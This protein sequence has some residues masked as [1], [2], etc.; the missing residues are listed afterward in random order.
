M[1]VATATAPSITGWQDLSCQVKRSM[2]DTINSDVKLRGAHAGN[3]WV[4]DGATQ[5]GKNYDRDLELNTDHNNGY[6]GSFGAS[7]PIGGKITMGNLKH[8][9][10]SLK[11]KNAWKDDEDLREKVQSLIDKP[12]NSFRAPMSTKES[13]EYTSIRKSSPE[14]QAKYVARKGDQE[15]AIQMIN[16]TYE[17][18]KLTAESWLKGELSD[19]VETKLDITNIDYFFKNHNDTSTD[20]KARRQVHRFILGEESIVKMSYKDSVKLNEG[21]D[22]LN[23]EANKI[24][25]ESG[26]EGISK[27][28]KDRHEKLANL[29]KKWGTTNSGI[30]ES[31]WNSE[32]EKTKSDLKARA[33]TQQAKAEAAEREKLG[34]FTATE[35][36]LN[37]ANVDSFLDTQIHL[38]KDPKIR[39]SVLSVLAGG[40]PVKVDVG[41]DDSLKKFQ[42]ST[43]STETV[44]SE[45]DHETDQSKLGDKVKAWQE[46]RKRKVESLIS[47]WEETSQVPR[48]RW[49][50]RN[51]PDLKDTQAVVSLM[52]VDTFLSDYSSMAKDPSAQAAV[53]RAL[54]QKGTVVDLGSTEEAS[55]L[56][57][58]SKEFERQMM[59]FKENEDVEGTKLWQKQRME[60][61]GKTLA[62][63]EEIAGKSYKEW[64]TEARSSA[65]DQGNSGSGSSSGSSVAVLR[66]S[67]IESF[68]QTQS[69]LARNP[70]VLKAVTTVLTAGGHHEV[71]VGSSEAASSLTKAAVDTQKTASK[72]RDKGR[73]AFKK[74]SSEREARI[75]KYLGEWSQISGIPKEHLRGGGSSRGG[76]KSQS[77]PESSGSTSNDGSGS[78]SSTPSHSSGPQAVTSTA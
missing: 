69:S 37:S 34:P 19:Q 14:G 44:I 68:L 4:S 52:N 16:E 38:A 11:E 7:A 46:A 33:K 27:W 18:G 35:T 10:L 24:H 21:L 31:D 3:R 15:K 40:K 48:D 58:A 55:T 76:G 2:A 57:K 49:I 6:D 54:Q 77:N 73:R 43:K 25:E 32:L 1:S 47:K 9:L 61:I 78:D 41:T 56:N 12:G 74:W 75:D 20:P 45:F 70:D 39:E 72:Y 28:R 8:Y 66:S 42:E 64:N 23:K 22:D 29:A 30:S 36:I 53:L 50:S 51:T 59:K 63:W 13:T 17:K 65:G 5:D 62:K 67:N 71:D 26:K 60:G